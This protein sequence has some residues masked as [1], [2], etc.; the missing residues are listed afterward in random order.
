M[1]FIGDIVGG[2]GA[3]QLGQYN[4]SLLQQQ[5]KLEKI[6][7]ERRKA[8]WNQLDKPRLVEN[9]KTEFSDFFVKVLKSGAEFR[10]GETGAL[11]ATKFR[12]SQ[13]YDLAIGEYN[14]KV[15]YQ[16]QINQSLMTSAKG[17]AELYKGELAYRT[18][19]IKAAGTMAGNYY[20]TSGQSLLG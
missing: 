3:K 8:V 5:S 16:N 14:S 19:L 9:Q 10:A 6:E 2:Y 4:N 12:I 13:A 15:D 7:A 1:S 20:K 18:G 11:A 17:Q